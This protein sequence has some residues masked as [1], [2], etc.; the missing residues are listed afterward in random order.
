MKRKDAKTRRAIF[1]MQNPL[2]RAAHLSPDP[3]VGSGLSVLS[4]PLTPHDD[5]ATA[6]RKLR[7]LHAAVLDLTKFKSATLA[8]LEKVKPQ[9]VT[10]SESV[11]KQIEVRQMAAQALE[12]AKA[13]GSSVPGHEVMSHAS[14]QCLIS[15]SSGSIPDKEL[16]E[17]ARVQSIDQ[18]Y[19]SLVSHTPKS[20]QDHGAPEDVQ[21]LLARFR[22]VNDVIFVM[23]KY[24]GVRDSGTYA[25]MGGMTGLPFWKEWVELCK[26]VQLDLGTGSSTTGGAWVPTVWSGNLIMLVQIAARCVG[27][28][29]WFPM[30]SKTQKGFV[31]GADLEAYY[32][33]E[34]VSITPSDFTTFDATWEAKKMAARVISSREI[35]QDSAI[36]FVQEI[37]RKLAKAIARATENLLINGQATGTTPGGAGSLDTGE[38]IAAGNIRLLSN[39]LR[40]WHAQ[41]G[42]GVKNAAGGLTIEGCAKLRGPMG[43]YG[44]DPAFMLWLC[45][46]WGAAHLLTLR[47]ET[48]N[49]V[50]LGQMINNVSPPG[51]VGRLLDSDIVLSSFVPDNMNANGVIDGAGAT[52][53]IYYPNRD[54]F[55][56]G[57]RLGI[58]VEASTH[59]KFDTDQ[60]VF[61]AVRRLDLQPVRTP[62]ASEPGIHAIGNLALE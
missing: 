31:E 53:A 61:K 12:L 42:L 60:V 7:E 1:G 16:V 5:E 17:M 18:R 40:Y 3:P 48:G 33:A 24:F 25:Q 37:E 58:V 23:N 55:K 46:A 45:S 22:L 30:L 19:F 9:L 20:V 14:R 50:F 10:L 43:A 38:T 2:L 28:F 49:P 62:S 56:F 27:Y 39:G 8:E 52:T 41:T 6:S 32:I 34:G 15:L 29:E 57:E 11:D 47:T 54:M 21:R 26:A 36:P 44:V 59:F 4:D 35:T 13:F 51:T